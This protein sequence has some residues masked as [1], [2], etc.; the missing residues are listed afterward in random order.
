MHRMTFKLLATVI[1]LCMTTAA[2][3]LDVPLTYV[4]HSDEKDSF[5][6]FSFAQVQ[7]T[8]ERPAG[9]WNLPEL[10]S[11]T[12]LYAFAELGDKECLL[13]LDRQNAD[14]FFFNRL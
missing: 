14:D 1:V 11:K 8:I 10:K 9:D 13:I 6:P 7:P 5:R 3:A 4:R 2:F 12:P